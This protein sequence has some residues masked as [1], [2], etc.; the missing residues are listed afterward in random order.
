LHSFQLQLNLSYQ[1]LFFVKNLLLFQGV[2]Q[3]FSYDKFWEWF[4]NCPYPVYVSSYTAPDDIKPL[5]FERKAQLLD[6]GHK[7]DNKQKKL[8]MENIYW[9]GKGDAEPL[10]ID[11]LFGGGGE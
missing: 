11:L 6:N 4:R 3:D 1:L 2:G 8:V 7:G 9:N 10:G 5:N